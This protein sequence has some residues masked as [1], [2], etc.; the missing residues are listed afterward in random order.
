MLM[1]LRSTLPVIL[2]LY[3]LALKTINSNYDEISPVAEGTDLFESGQEVVEESDEAHVVGGNSKI[4]DF[5]G[6]YN[7]EDISFLVLEDFFLHVDNHY[8]LVSSIHIIIQQHHQ[9]IITFIH[10]HT[11]LHL[12]EPRP[13]AP[14]PPQN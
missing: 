7:E 5:V 8:L 10:H 9:K 13:P 11:H 12:A 2:H 4:L 6:D 3:L 14:H 1:M